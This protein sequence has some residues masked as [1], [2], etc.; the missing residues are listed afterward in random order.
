MNS[1]HRTL[2]AA[3]T[4]RHASNDTAPHMYMHGP[5]RHTL[6]PADDGVQVPSP[7]VP[8]HKY[9]RLSLGVMVECELVL[10]GLIEKRG[11]LTEALEKLD[12]IMALVSSSG[13]A[14]PPEGAAEAQGEAAGDPR[15]HTHSHLWLECRCAATRILIAQGRY[16]LA[17]QLVSV[18]QQEAASLNEQI[19][20]RE[21]S[22]RVIQLDMH[23]GK[24]DLSLAA[25]QELVLKSRR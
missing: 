7:A 11:H 16:G 10:S 13:G 20:S 17:R 14:V 24:T 21:I 2:C 5:S 9:T 19:L 15:Q 4:I 12:A 1:P 6:E 22:L 23:E 25:V 3:Y 8:K 18:A